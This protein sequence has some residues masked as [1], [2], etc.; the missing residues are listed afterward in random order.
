M[1]S[2]INER[3]G[4]E[5]PAEKVFV[6][7]YSVVNHETPVSATRV[8]VPSEEGEELIHS[9]YLVFFEKTDDCSGRFVA[10]YEVQFSGTMPMDGAISI[11]F[12]D[13]PNLHANES[14]NILAVANIDQSNYIDDDPLMWLNNHFYGMTENNALL[15]T[16]AYIKGP[17][18]NN[19]SD[20]TSAILPDQILMSGRATKL[21]DV[22][23][24]SLELTRG[25][26][27]FDVYNLDK[28]NFDLVSVSIWN[29][30]LYGPVWSD[31][32]YD[33]PTRINRFY[34]IK[35]E[36]RTDESDPDMA[37]IIGGLYCPENFVSSPEK[38]DKVTTCLIVG[39]APR[40]G[41][42]FTGGVT[43]HRINMHPEDAGQNIKRNHVYKLN[44][45]RVNG[46]GADSEYVA[47]AG[48][49]N[50]L[51]VI[52]NNW[53]LDDNGMVLTD[54][55]NTLVI[56]VK[57][58]ILHPEGDQREYSVFTLGPGEPYISKMEMPSD[59]RVEL[60]G[61]RLMIHA[62]ELPAG[63]D[64]RRG[65][66]EIALG[67]LKGEIIFIQGPNNEHYLTLNRTDLPSFPAYG[68]SPIPEG[69]IEITSSG[70]WTARI[71]NNASGINPGFAFNIASI[72][73]PEVQRTFEENNFV[74]VLQIYTTGANPN[75]E[76][77]YSFVTISLDDNPEITRSLVL[78]QRPA[79][80]LEIRP[81]ASTVYFT[82]LGL[83]V[84]TTGNSNVDGEYVYFQ[85]NPGTDVDGINA[86]YAELITG[87][88]YFELV[89]ENS[90][91]NIDD[92]K[93]RI[94]AKGQNLSGIPYTGSVRIAHAGGSTSESLTLQITQ[95][96]AGFELMVLGD[97][98][99]SAKGGVI[100]GV[101]VD[102]NQTLR[103]SA[104][105]L[106]NTAGLAHDHQ[107][108]LLDANGTDAGSEL[109][110]QS[111]DVL[112][113]VGFPK[114]LTPNVGIAPQAVVEVSIDGTDMK[115][116]FTV[117]QKEL[118]PNN[119]YAVNLST[120]RGRISNDRTYHYY[121]RFYNTTLWDISG[122]KNS[123]G[124]SLYMSA[125]KVTEE[126]WGVTNTSAIPASTTHVNANYLNPMGSTT[127]SNIMKWK[128]D[129]EGVL[130][131]N[132][133]Y[134]ERTPFNSGG[135]LNLLGYQKGTVG[136]GSGSGRNGIR[137]NS[138]VEHTKVYQYIFE[139]GP[140][141]KVNVGNITKWGYDDTRTVLSG[142]PSTAVP[143][144]VDGNENAQL[145][146]DPENRVVFNGELQIF[147]T[148]YGLGDAYS[149]PLSGPATDYHRFLANYVAFIHNVAMYGTH[150]TDHFKEETL[151]APPYDYM[152]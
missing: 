64:E 42:G 129:N 101:R 105:I 10:P 49:E 127:S 148:E 128:Q 25:L 142:Y 9:L 41:A 77:R 31:A 136:N 12:T 109:T 143:I 125:F 96:N 22:Q 69:V 23:E 51:D 76:P 116:M 151:T 52:I 38:N 139:K 60:T 55:K 67:S 45:N 17:V 85:I 115:K 71:Y 89:V 36:G 79:T 126:K 86:W 131:I 141:G 26:V 2:C 75:N 93:I 83:P 73:P 32:K 19:E 152:R 87:T 74:N 1:T 43:Y 56:P 70:P 130:V 106:S 95:E 68:F 24:V 4:G 140:F 30:A 123:E 27:R 107:A 58:V 119:I 149:I 29:A 88:E 54:G 133:D 91:L 34:G 16:M 57:R 44:I 35:R 59:I 117:K 94:K 122:Y 112:V 80:N 33:A 103:W 14:Y 5:T 108:Y 18:D 46:P 13:V 118:T 104:K 47:W 21:A 82:E 99:V 98:E 120:E 97:L 65:M 62:A 113:K 28:E 7:N 144:L 72:D 15:T 146:I 145:L 150:F 81:Q 66:V 50:N 100:E 39:I 37:N 6:V 102:A 124:K 110:G 11:P 114:L 8:S 111:V 53:N 90:S 3:W 20:N 84:A 40:E 48:G 137:I 135:L 78:I 132:H 61:N 134:V 121:N 92:H 138:D 63:Q 147:F